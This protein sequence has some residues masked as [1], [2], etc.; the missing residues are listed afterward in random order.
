MPNDTEAGEAF[1]A[2]G[3][4]VNQRAVVEL[5][6]DDVTVK[7]KDGT[8]LSAVGAGRV[9]DHDAFTANK[10]VAVEVDAEFEVGLV[11]GPEPLAG[12][13]K[14]GWVVTDGV[15]PLLALVGEG[16]V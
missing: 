5:H 13:A 4:Q 6:S 7:V 3:L 2:D 15:P 14:P 1:Q 8:A 16:G 12:M 9:D 10:V 11:V